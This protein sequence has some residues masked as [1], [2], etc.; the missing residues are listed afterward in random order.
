MRVATITVLTADTF[1]TGLTATGF[2]TS[3]DALEMPADFCEVTSMEDTVNFQSG[4]RMPSDANAGDTFG[5]VNA[6]SGGAP[7][8]VYPSSG[9]IFLPAGSV[10]I[11]PVADQP[12][13]LS[14]GQTASIKCVAT[15]VFAITVSN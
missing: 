13:F 15:G 10:G 11:T 2:N 4:I 12:A 3:A 6:I 9:G 5:L 14:R 1:A 8:R 7:I